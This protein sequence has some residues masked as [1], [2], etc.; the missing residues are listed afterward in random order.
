MD[1]LKHAPYTKAEICKGA[2]VSVG[3]VNTLIEKGVLSPI[4]VEQKKEFSL[5]NPGHHK[6]RLTAEQRAAADILASKVGQGFRLPCWTGL[7]ARAKP[8]FILRRWPKRWSREN[9]RWSW[10][11]K[12]R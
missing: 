3:V 2:G 11:R 10:C 6:V 5:P 4:A 7:P 9:R 8:K 12:F 1:L